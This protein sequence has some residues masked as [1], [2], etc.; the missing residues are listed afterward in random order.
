M[1]SELIDVVQA[2]RSGSLFHR[3]IFAIYRRLRLVL[4]WLRIDDYLYLKQAKWRVSFAQEKII[5]V[6]PHEKFYKKSRELFVQKEVLLRAIVSNAISSG[7]IDAKKNIVDVGCFIGDN[8]LPWAKM[9]SGTVYA[10]DP[11]VRNIKF[12]E[13]MALI[14]RIGNVKTFLNA[15]GENEGF[16]YPAFDIDHTPFTSNPLSE[17]AKQNAVCVVSFDTLFHKRIIQNVGLLHLDVEGMELSTLRG[18]ADL[19]RSDRPD[20]LF[21]A[22]ITIDDTDA[23][24]NLLEGWEYVI[25]MMNESTLDGRPDC[26]NFIAFPKERDVRSIVQ[27]LNNTSVVGNY[28]KA[29][30]GPHLIPVP[31]R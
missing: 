3:I 29:T 16:I 19:I 28:F 31:A 23:I 10:L 2:K 22:H 25:Y 15:V 27:T 9:I 13:Q 8:A 20:I 1:T 6:V 12:V 5:L 30:V 21:E 11:A 17:R 18:S 24:F 26:I 4:V 7:I 14:N